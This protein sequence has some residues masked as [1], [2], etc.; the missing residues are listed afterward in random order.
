[1]SLIELLVAMA[2]LLV[3]MAS[4][5]TLFFGFWG[6]SRN[7][8]SLSQEQGTVRNT[9]R[10]LSADLRSADPLTLVPST[11]TSA[12]SLPAGTVTDPGTTGTNPTDVIAMYEN[13]DRYAPCATSTT[14]TSVPTPFSSSTFQANV[15]WAYNWKKGTLTRYSYV[16]ADSKAST[17]T[18]RA[19]GW[20]RGP[21]LSDVVNSVGT[22]FTVSQSCSLTTTTSTST[23]PQSQASSPSTTTASNNNPAAA[24]CGN[25]VNIFIKSKQSGQTGTFSISEAV[26]LPNQASVTSEAC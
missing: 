12:V 5:Y 18:C 21:S 2:I 11:F 24:W 7:S 19:G 8:I 1:M 15:V 17:A 9:V 13:T 6:S 3:I 26:P 23:C 22:M 14:T 16:A 4:F 10:I 20:L 25:T